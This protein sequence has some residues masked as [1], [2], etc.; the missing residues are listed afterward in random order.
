MAIDFDF[1]S[2]S[3]FRRLLRQLQIYAGMIYRVHWLTMFIFA[4][5]EKVQKYAGRER[6]PGSPLPPAAVE[7]SLLQTE[8]PVQ[9]IVRRIAVDGIADGLRLSED[10]VAEVISFAAC[11]PCYGNAEPDRRL[12]RSPCGCLISADAVVGDYFDGI[13]DCDVIRQLWGEPRIL[14]IARA[15]LGTRPLPLRSR[16]WWNFRADHATAEMRAV[17]SQNSFHFDLDDWRAVKFFFYMTDVG[18]ENGPH[19]YVRKS[20]R[21][22]TMRDQLSPFK[23]RTSH[24]LVSRY[25]RDNFAV[26]RGPAGAGFVEDPYGFHTGTAVRGAARLMLEF[27]YGVSRPPLVGGPFYVPAIE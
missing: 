16:L 24:Y 8:L 1:L 27:E 20:H 6:D 19:I 17:H 11:A 22:R 2:P 13:A 15:S 7:P 9:E 12:D 5:F 4:R 21:I 23:S 18:D 14:A 10:S 25:G 26:M 3:A